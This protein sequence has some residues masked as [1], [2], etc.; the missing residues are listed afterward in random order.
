MRLPEI[1]GGAGLGLGI[2]QR[3]EGPGAS[4]PSVEG[5]ISGWVPAFAGTAG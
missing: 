5:G 1:G 2:G 3:E 4:L